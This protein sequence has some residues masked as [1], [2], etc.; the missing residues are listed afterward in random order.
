VG[1]TLVD[2]NFVGSHFGVNRILLEA[3]FGRMEFGGIPFWSKL[4]FGR[5]GL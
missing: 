4:D 2:R 1:L 3:D 5:T